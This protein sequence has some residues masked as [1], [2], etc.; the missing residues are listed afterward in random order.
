ME[1]P[2]PNAWEYTETTKLAAV[3][4]QLDDGAQELEGQWGTELEGEWENPAQQRTN[5]GFSKYSGRFKLQCDLRP[6]GRH[7]DP[8]WPQEEV[9]TLTEEGKSA[10]RTTPPPSCPEPGQPWAGEATPAPLVLVGLSFCPWKVERSGLQ[11]WWTH[12]LILLW[13]CSLPCPIPHSPNM[14][15]GIISQ[16]NIQPSNPSLKIYFLESKPKGDLDEHLRSVRLE[17]RNSRRW[18]TSRLGRWQYSDTYE[19]ISFPD[20]GLPVSAPY[21]NG[22]QRRALQLCPWRPGVAWGCGCGGGQ[23]PSLFT[24]FCGRWAACPTDICGATGQSDCPLCFHL[25][26]GGQDV[27]GKELP[28]SWGRGPPRPHP[29]NCWLTVRCQTNDDADVSCTP[30][31]ASD[32]NSGELGSNMT[33]LENDPGQPLTF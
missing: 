18:C 7:S 15:L 13:H 33:G 30:Q 21:R 10:N 6:S 29:V 28:L 24:R 19:N 8:L 25:G 27:K 5:L 26:S 9:W 12:Q 23:F 2:L 14:F 22:H 3:F 31:H 4:W 32:T 20:D 17:F 16:K 11:Q 1:V